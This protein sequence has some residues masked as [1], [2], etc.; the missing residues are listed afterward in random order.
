M[1]APPWRLGIE[2]FFRYRGSIAVMP[3]WAFVDE[4]ISEL[5]P[6]LIAAPSIVPSSSPQNHELN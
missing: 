5:T 2:V 4:Q 1:P 3:D 6:P